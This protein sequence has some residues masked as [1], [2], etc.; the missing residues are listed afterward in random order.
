MALV[1]PPRRGV[2]SHGPDRTRGQDQK[3]RD[4]ATAT[5]RS[6]I[7]TQIKLA[8]CNSCGSYV[9]AVAGVA[10]EPTPL[11][12]ESYRAALIAGR[13]TYDVITE[14]GRPWRLR[15]RTASVSSDACDIVASHPCG[16]GVTE[17]AAEP[18]AAGAAT[19]R[20]VKS[21][22]HRC[23]TCRRLIDDTEPHWAVDHDSFHWAV[24]DECPGA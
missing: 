16:A 9:L 14:A 4:L 24:H 22:P 1:E 23:R 5:Q 7:D 8:T 3:R 6:L 17:L 18:A 2:P 21:W 10:A 13:S 20:P 11:D 12:A 19:S 15:L